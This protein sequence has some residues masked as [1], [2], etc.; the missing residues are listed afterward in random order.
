MKAIAGIISM[1]VGM[2]A[3]IL[4]L[5]HFAYFG[6]SQAISSVKRSLTFLGLNTVRTLVRSVSILSQ[7]SKE[8]ALISLRFLVGREHSEWSAGP[9]DHEGG[10][11]MQFMI[12]QLYTVGELYDVGIMALATNA[13]T[14][15]VPFSWMLQSR[16][17]RFERQSSSS[18][19]LPMLRSVPI[20]WESGE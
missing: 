15:M 6:A 19:E 18:L 3:T 14:A 13:T 7:F 2:T 16:I 10:R 4:Q 12:D 11:C 8:D 20:C 9:G 1:D 17:G 5:V